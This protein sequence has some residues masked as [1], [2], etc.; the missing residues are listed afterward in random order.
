MTTYN[1]P[2]LIKLYKT[3]SP[4]PDRWDEFFEKCRVMWTEQPN[5]SLA[6]LANIHVQTL[7]IT[8]GLDE[9]G[10]SKQ[11]QEM[12]ASLQNCQLL[13]FPDADHS[14]HMTNPQLINECIRDFF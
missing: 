1:Y 5:H 14:I 6:A 13:N 9:W 2:F 8:V 10:G 12:Q 4:T 3:L 7:I 11:A